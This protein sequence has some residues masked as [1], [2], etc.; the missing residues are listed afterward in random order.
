MAT[1][2]R[3]FFAGVGT[4]FVILTVG[5]GAGIMLGNTVM[6]PAKSSRS[7]ADQLPQVRVVLPASG[8]AS[9]PQEQP[10]AQEHTVASATATEPVAPAPEVTSPAVQQVA[11]I[12]KNKQEDRAER[13]KADAEKQARRKRLAE[14]KARRDA[15]RVVRQEQEPPI[16]QQPG[17]MAFGGDEQ[18]RKG[19]FGGGFFGD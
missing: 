19:G 17:I 2:T 13:R 14:R 4:T 5:F 7:A 9:L 18:P 3:A 6:E 8:E 12:E 1:S 15:V 10:V 16:R 11:Q